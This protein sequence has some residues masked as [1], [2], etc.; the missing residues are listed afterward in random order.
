MLTPPGI[1]H[2]STSLGSSVRYMPERS[3][4][5]VPGLY[6]STQSG[7]ISFGIVYGI[8]VAVHVFVY[9]ELGR[10][11]LQAVDAFGVT[12]CVSGAGGRGRRT[13]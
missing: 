8:G 5:S 1:C 10:V 2:L 3:I 11:E 6:N 7:V 12:S 9:I 13:T 4:S